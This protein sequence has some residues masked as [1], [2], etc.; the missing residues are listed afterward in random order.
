MDWQSTTGKYYWEAKLDAFGGSSKQCGFGLVDGVCNI[1]GTINGK[2]VLYASQPSGANGKVFASNNT[3]GSAITG[4]W[5]AGDIFSMAVDLGAGTFKVRRNGGAW[6]VDFTLPYSGPWQPVCSLYDSGDQMTFYFDHTTW[7][8][9]APAGYD[10][11]HESSSYTGRYWKW[12]SIVGTGG[13]QNIGELEMRATLSGA[14]QTGSGTA[15]ASSTFG[16]NPGTYDP[17]KA[18]D[19][20]ASTLWSSN[21]DQNT[22]WWMYDF[23]SATTVKEIA[24]KLRNDI[25]TQYSTYYKWMYSDD[26]TNWKIGYMKYGDTWTTAGE[27]H[28]YAVCNG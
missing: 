16:S 14:D 10:Q 8:Y 11:W 18:V 19:N 27:T 25:N 5:A 28:T 26:G 24:F 20:N 9:S 1:D 17:S 12:Q 7:T 4:V 15:T 3:S 6:S 2:Y 13:G 22:S 21:G 23:G